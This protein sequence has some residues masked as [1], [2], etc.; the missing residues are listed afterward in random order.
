MNEI[1]EPSTP[2]PDA[3]PAP[4]RAAEAPQE[5]TVEGFFGPA[6]LL[7]LVI[8]GFLGFAVL[9]HRAAAV[10]VPALAPVTIQLGSYPQAAAP[11]T[12]AP[13]PL[14]TSITPITS[15]SAPA[16]GMVY[17]GD[18]YQVS[19]NISGTVVLY[20]VVHNGTAWEPP[21]QGYGCT[22]SNDTDGQ[23]QCIF[24]ARSGGGLTW[25]VFRTG[26]GSV[27]SCLASGRAGPVPA[28]RPQPPSSGPGSGTVTSVG[29]SLPAEFNVT[30]SPVTTS[31]T[32]TGAWA[33]ETANRVFAGPA[34]GGAATPTFRAL[35][36]GDLPAGTGT[37][38]SITQGTGMSF[39]VT[40]ITTTGTINLA[41]TAVTPAT[42]GDATHVAQVA[43]DQQGRATGASNVLITGTTPGGACGGDLS[44]TFPNCTVAKINTVALGTTTATN[45]H[46]L[47]ADGS[48]WQSVAMSGDAT[49]SNAGALTLANTAVSSASYPSAGQIPTFTVDQKG[50][51]TAAGS[52]TSGTALTGVFA[53]ML[54]LGA[55]SFA[56]GD[57]W[58]VSPLDAGHAASTGARPMFDAPAGLVLGAIA[59]T[60]DAVCGTGES[61]TITAQTST[62]HGTSYSDSAQVCTISGNTNNFCTAAGGVSVSTST[63]VAWKAVK[64][65]GCAGAFNAICTVQ[66]SK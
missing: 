34:S 43:I 17:S 11:A 19:C 13:G 60:I 12:A 55:S 24:P 31:G 52:T 8:L 42:Y 1:R 29:L 26:S 46:L 36:A 64:S 6:L 9:Q 51:L 2:A 56:T 4:E 54:T 7:G 10:L 44:G 49:I 38:T 39:S 21:Y 3:A 57:N 18:S 40:P 28:S 61:L 27:S 5:R 25:N 16:S 35:V 59:C 63:L 66:I 58:L 62:D 14:A 45:A 22:L 65:S 53:G 50:R 32:L 30:G 41:N 47:V 20:P 37:V 23:G 33:T 15:L 48:A